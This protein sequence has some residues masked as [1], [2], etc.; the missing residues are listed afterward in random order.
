MILQTLRNVHDAQLLN[1]NKYDIAAGLSDVPITQPYNYNLNY[2][3]SKQLRS[4]FNR[5]LLLMMT[6]N[7]A[8]ADILPV[9]N[10]IIAKTTIE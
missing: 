7:P 5:P 3:I 9:S 8:A 1:I 4:A 10:T 2:S 6:A